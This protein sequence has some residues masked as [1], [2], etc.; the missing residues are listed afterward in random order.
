MTRGAHEQGAHEDSP[1]PRGLHALAPW[2]WR[3]LVLVV[4]LLAVYVA[5]G[6]F[7]MS[8]APALRL[9][10][11]GELNR[12]LPFEVQVSQLA[13]SWSAFSPELVFYGLVLTPPEDGAEPIALGSGRIRFDVP[14]SIAARSLRVSRLELAE[15]ALDAVLTEEGR[16]EVAGFGLGAGGDALR[17]WLEAFLP[18][19]RQVNLTD[20]RLCLR[21]ADDRFDVRLDLGLARTGNAR[22][23]QAT[24]RGERMDVA[25]NAEGVGNPLHPRSWVGDLFIDAR[26]ADLA[27]MSG[28]WE[29]LDWPFRLR[30]EAGVQFW[31]SREGG[32]STARLRWDSAGLEIEERGGAWALPLDALTFEAALDQRAQHWSLLTQAFHAERSGRALDL[33]RAQ[34]D[35]WGQGLRI[36]A[37][38]LSLAA[39]PTIFAA[40]PG[41]PPGLREALPE[42]APT[43]Y[44][45]AVELRLDDLAHPGRSW[46]LR[47]TLDNLAVASWRATPAVEG[48]TGYLDLHP[49]GGRLQLDAA[50]FSVHFPSVFRAPLAYRD[51]LG[52]LFFVWNDEGLKIASGLLA[53]AAPEGR[54][55]GLFALDIPFTPRATG[56]ELGLLIGLA[57]SGVE[58][59]GKYLPYKL[60]PPLLDWLDRSIV[61]G[62]VARAAFVWRGSL[63]KG[64][65][66]HASS[67][68]FFDVRRATLR[69]DP[70]WPALTDADGSVWIDNGR[71]YGRARRA[72]SAGL[73]L[74]DLV[75]RALPRRG[76]VDLSAAAGFRGDAAAAGA[77]LRDSPLRTLTKGVFAAWD[78]AGRTQGRLAFELPLDRFESSP[79]LDLDL[80]V[81]VADA[82][83]RIDQIDLGLDEVEGH[84]VY[85][86]DTGFAGSTAQ[87]AALDGRFAARI[88]GAQTLQFEAM[89]EVS[90]I[91]E[92]LDLP[93][94]RFA[95]G[96]TVFD[97]TLDLAAERGP[98]FALHS[99]LV[100]IDL[101]VPKPF[102]KSAE[103][104]LE[105]TLTLPVGEAADARYW[106]A[107]LGERLRVDLALREGGVA[108][109]RAALGMGAG[110]AR[111]DTAACEERYCLSG[112]VSSL[113][114]AAWA[115]FY[116]RYIAAGAG[117]DAAKDAPAPVSYRIDAL[118][119]GE[120]RL[121]DRLLGSARLDLWGVDTLWQGSLKSDW[122]QGRLTREDG[123]SRL[124]I[125]YL[126]SERLGGAAP[127]ALA[128]VRGLLPS[129]R[130]DILDLRRGALSLGR[131]GFDLD[132]GHDPSGLYFSNLRGELWG[133][134]L[135]DPWPGLLRWYLEDGREYT[136]LELDARFAKAQEVLTAVGF[137]PTLES[138]SGAVGVRLRW[139]GD[140]SAFAIAD[141]NGSI[142]LSATHGRILEY[143]PGAL[144]VISFLNLA[145]ILR[146]LSLAHVFESGIPFQRASAEFYLRERMLKVTDLQIDG[147]ASAFTF[148]GLS[149]L[150]RRSIDG[151]LVVTL[152]VANNLPWI[153]ALAAGLALPEAAGVFVVSKV[154]EKQVKRM[155][156]AVYGVSGRIESPDVE[157]RRLFDDQLTPM[158]P[159][160]ALGLVVKHR[161]PS[162]D[163]GRTE[164][165]R[166]P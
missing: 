61:A 155:S 95:S 158:G 20:N 39:L 135:D 128:D 125:E 121:A 114:I 62:D 160:G 40:G 14:A 82:R 6:R 72:H 141:A 163:P 166:R 110:G 111:S 132:A 21:T 85:D 59:R 64:L 31:L 63:K 159:G 156:S 41:L 152:P 88:E 69:Y 151:E 5:A 102:D 137:A 37:S 66:A 47:A 58:Y 116:R 131:L 90:A 2:L 67:Q 148:K 115:D 29:P 83:V 119:I 48:L 103:Q 54:A 113:D 79:P 76:G 16:I 12:R 100:G 106:R 120:L 52:E 133:L 112:S 43:G 149:D 19:V 138:A 8:Q 89:A 11:L 139:P 24:L 154:L 13:G 92:W 81:D 35:W 130:V 86:R 91:A 101:D 143:K 118:A 127:A 30:G 126:D 74:E 75:V 99:E 98:R 26:L 129:M 1:L 145:E 107:R 38:D 105:L 117:V 164:S 22:R 7:I 157:F 28:L 18:N 17:L 140:P 50:D 142:A 73:A 60:P 146:G 109:L 124:L 33:D 94:L 23:L 153:V 108:G 46:Q 51:V 4:V 104:P 77:L 147:P 144:S 27:R 25:V 80:S 136:Q 44:L 49:R 150:D 45:Q 122:A 71:A 134:R 70:A 9:A 56:F 97:G 68:L 96:R 53:L 10:L 36:R 84:L 165:R 42:L 161:T 15:L 55:R 162:P 78:F 123:E 87:G 57:D 3:V 93:L 32:D 34:F 65:R